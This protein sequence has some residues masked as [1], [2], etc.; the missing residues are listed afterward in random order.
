MGGGSTGVNYSPRPG[1]YG[2]LGTPDAGNIPGGRADAVSWTDNSGNFWLFG[3]MGTDAIGSM[4]V[5]NDLWEFNSETIQWTW[6]GGSSTVGSNCALV[7]YCGQSGIYGTLYT[8][9]AGNL[10]GGRSNAVKWTDSNGN[11]WLFGGY[12]YDANGDLGELN[13][14]WKFN[15]AIRQWAW[16]GGSTTMHSKYRGMPGVYGVLGTPAPGNA[17]GG[18]TSAMSWVD[19]NGNFWLFGGVGFDS[20]G[21]FGDLNDLWKFDPP[22]NRWAWMGGSSTI[23]TICDHFNDCGYPGVYG[24]LGTPASGNIPGSRLLA[25]TWV[26]SSG[27]VWLF[28]GTGFDAGGAWGP[29]NDLWAFFPSTSQWAWMGGSS[30]IRSNGFGQLGVYGTLGVPDAGNIPAAH[31]ESATWVDSSG[32]LWLFGGWT[33]STCNDLWEFNPSTSEWTWWGGSGLSNNEFGVYG[34]LGIPAPGNFPGSHTGSVAWTDS[35]GQAWIFA[36]DGYDADSY[37]I[38][39]DL[40]TYQPAPILPRVAT[41]TFN[42]A[43]GTYA[44]AQTVTISDTTPGAVIYYTTNGTAPT[45]SSSIYSTPVTVSATETIE[46]IAVATGYSNSAVATA[47]Y[48]ITLPAAMPSFSVP[49]GTYATPQTVTITDTT[50]G[51]VI[52]YTINGTTPTTASSTYSTPVTVSTS[53]TIEAI[54]VATGY[55][56]SAIATA[57][58][59]IT[60]SNSQVG[61]WTWMAGSSTVG[62]NSGQPA[63]YGKLGVPA[64]ANTPG[65][66]SEATSWTDASGR[67]WFFGGIAYGPNSK[68]LFLND[69]WMF[70]DSLNEWTW[71]SGSSTAPCP[72]TT[73]CGQP[74]VYGTVGTPAAGN[75]PGGRDDAVSWADN[76]GNLWLYGGVGFDANGT[77]G[78]LN[79]LWKFNPATGI[80]TW[81]GGNTTLLPPGIGQLPV[82]GTLGTP[83]SGN[84]PGGRYAATAWTDSNGRFW[85]FGGAG[86]YLA[87]ETT[88]STFNDLWQFDPATNEWTWMGGS[89]TPGTYCPYG[90]C[91]QPGIYGTRGTPA[92]GNIPGSRYLSAT[93]TDQSGH[94][95]LFGG[96][97]SGNYGLNDLWEYYPSLNE[98]AWMGGGS[99]INQPGVYGTLGTPASGNY[100]GGR[101]AA[102]G[103]IDSNGLFW[104]FGGGGTDANGNPGVLLNDLWMLNPSTNEWAWMG[105]S[106]TTLAANAGVYGTLGVSAPGNVPGSRLDS[107]KWSDKNGNLWLFGGWG[108]DAD[109]RQGYLNDVWRYGAATSNLPVAATPTFNPPAGTYAVAQTVTISDT[110]PG[111][112]IYY[113]TNGTAPTTSSSLYSTP[114]TVSTTE[115]IEAIAVATG[116]SDSAVATAAYT[117]TQSSLPATSTTLTASATSLTAGQV[118]TLTATVLSGSTAVTPGQVNFCDAAAAYC[119]DIH[120]LGTAQLTSSGTATLK[121][122]PAPG[123][124]SYKA[125][126]LGT[127]AVASSI[128]NVVSVTVA[129]SGSHATTTT[130]AQSGGPGNY[131]LTATVTGDSSVIPTGT[132]SFLDTSNANYVLGTGQL[133]P[134]SGTTA[135]AFVKSSSPATNQWPQSVAVGDFNGDGKPD[136]A[137]PVYSVPGLS[138]LLGNGDGTFTAG[139][140]APTVSANVNNAVV[141]DFNGDGKADI[142]LSLPDDYKVQVLLGKGDGSFTALPAISAGG[143]WQLA[144]GDFNSD[145]KADLIIVNC[146]AR[147]LTALLGNGDGTFNPVATTSSLAQCPVSVAVGDFAGNG[148][149]DLAVAIAPNATGVP[150]AVTILLGNGDGTFTPTAQNLVTGD[151]AISIVA[152]DF[153]GNGILDLAV[154]NAYIGT[155]NPGTLSLFLGNGDGTF[156][157][158]VTSPVTGSMPYSVAVGDFNG[159]GKADLVTANVGSN[160]ATVLLGNGDGTF[161][162]AASPSS[163]AGTAFAATGDFN[164]DGL[165]DIAVVD[166]NSGKVTILLAHLTGMA[167]ATATVTGI[168]PV[169]TGTHLVNANYPGDGYYSGSISATTPL[170]AEPVVTTLSLTANPTSSTQGQQVLFTATVNPS[171]AQ[172]HNATGMVTFY[173]GATSL[174]TGTVA[175][176]V[177]TLSTNALPAGTNSITASYAGDTNFAASQSSALPFT[178]TATT[179]ATTTTLTASAANLTY[180]Q[181]LTLTATVT[182]ASGAIPTGTVTFL[183]GATSLGTG[184]LNSSGVATLVLTPAVGSY[185]ITASY[186]GSL[187]DLSSISAPPVAITVIAAATTTTLGASPNPAAF[188]A[189]VTFTATVASSTATPAGTV[190]FYDGAA[191][192]GTATLASGVA[193][194]S[195][196]SLS[197]GSH[198]ISAHFAATT[199]FNASTSNVVIEVISPADFSISVSPASQTVYTG[200]PATYTVTIKPGTGFNLPVSL[201]CSQLP[202]N[203]ACSFSPS[204]IPAGAKTSVLIVRTSAPHKPSTAFTLVPGVRVTALAGLLL[205]LVPRRSL[206]RR[207]RLSIFLLLFSFLAIGV[208][209]SACGSSGSLLGGTPV[210]TQTIAVTGTATNGTQMLTH[211]ATVK[212]NVK[213]LF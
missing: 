8:F 176:G 188:G 24:A 184:T 58:Y 62:S 29:L 127:T 212:L 73:F 195:T 66:R 69:L 119:T 101:Y 145:G 133:I 117:I 153:R 41:P 190:S 36:G 103:W 148:K 102:A 44:V 181:A 123:S 129:T 150:G 16:M 168:S 50:P 47:A 46:A 169:G 203:T 189:N 60:P 159:D 206:W 162:T 34:T 38:L 125:I 92:P 155:S 75:A 48:T 131:T 12:G 85:L 122:M 147:T 209:L 178:V 151:S 79:D 100:P 49:A 28:G 157:S 143:I 109:G 197:V 142:A 179:I 200:E 182:P 175:N 115:T 14:L 208:S 126:F 40:W 128:S 156:V 1:V 198:N 39:N 196:S 96:A 81:M 22:T 120:L 192:I 170:T 136:L 173:N 205:L 158:T 152:G 76:A 98:W 137:V 71:M 166:N 141:A 177:A 134:G 20:S 186:S 135:L 10:P 111:A 33:T 171:Q 91:Q 21:G 154:A 108:A 174:G 99:A 118:L 207:G 80:W 18:R 86:F 146:G 3:G 193:T 32:H 2:T 113:T 68:P 31:G 4:G 90:S 202:A 84:I 35:R 83:A 72:P 70:D 6:M 104:L 204:T 19:S 45:A 161:N 167:T 107:V 11:L 61:Q 112:V 55:S 87:S 57:A 110:T 97:V 82:Y 185:S 67:L 160:T 165:S 74:G 88:T 42:P 64:A 5:L 213:S 105:G 54:A 139:P 211:T 17:P 15:P 140:V 164:G 149:A 95:W 78:V 114:I 9:A 43:A 37:G 210:G 23:G 77:F 144:G 124:H 183:N 199:S 25:V 13:D 27:R 53:E 138:I 59:T 121:F 94:L 130:I 7:S 116:Y 63:V 89:N 30:T 201:S 191:Q 65:G 52:Y 51:A 180:G 194:Y 26:D 187:T 106:S 93:W 56:N 132:V 163:G 172:N